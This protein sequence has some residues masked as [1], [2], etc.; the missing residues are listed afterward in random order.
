VTDARAQF[1]HALHHG[2]EINIH[3]IGYPNPKVSGTAYFRR[4]AGGT[5]QGL[6]WHAP[7]IE[8]VSA[9]EV[10]LDEGYFPAQSRCARRRDQT[11]CS[12]T[13]D[14]HIVASIRLGVNPLRGVHI[15]DQLPIV[16]VKG[17]RFW[18]SAENVVFID[19]REYPFILLTIGLSSRL[20]HFK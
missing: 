12:P 7:D 1:P 20:E 5:N 16:F 19:Q 15:G 2:G 13:D 8:A 11:R 10:S 14:D 6:R 18:D 9:H 3:I 4:D 17:G